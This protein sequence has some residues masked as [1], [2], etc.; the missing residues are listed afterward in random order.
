MTEKDFVLGDFLQQLSTD[1]Y[2]YAHSVNVVAYSVALAMRA[3]HHNHAVL[4]ELANGALLHDVGESRVEKRILQKT[5]A[6][7]AKE[8]KK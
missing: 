8:W 5:D 6:L 1:Y 3:G 2:I 7:N 4:R